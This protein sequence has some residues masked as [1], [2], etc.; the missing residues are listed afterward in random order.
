[1]DADNQAEKPAFEVRNP[2]TGKSYKIYASGWTEGFEDMG[3][4][5]IVNRIP[6]IVARAVET[7]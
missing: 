2:L 5:C 6:Q 7:R 1:M 4:R 3:P